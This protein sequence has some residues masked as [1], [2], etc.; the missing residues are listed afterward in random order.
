MSMTSA[1][2][3]I[4]ARDL[5][6]DFPDL[7][8]KSLFGAAPRIPVL[9]GINLSIR[10]G[11]SVGIV[12][13]SGSGKTTLGRCLLRLHE[14]TSGQ[15]LFAG[16]DYTHIDRSNLRSLR[17]QMQMIFQDPLSS[18]NPRRKIGAIV[19]QP[20]L[21]SRVETDRK[22]AEARAIQALRRTGLDEGFAGRYPHELSG[23]QRQRVGIARAIVCE[24]KF[25]LADEIVSGLDV[26]TQAQ[27]LTLLRDLQREMGLSLAFI[28]HDL[29][30]VRVLCDRVVVMLNGKIVEEGRCEDVFDSP[31]SDYARQLIDAVPLPDLDDDWLMQGTEIQREET[32]MDVK[33]KTVLV[34]G[35]NRGIGRAYV[36]ELINRGAAKIYAGVRTSGSMGNAGDRVREIK[37]DV[38]SPADVKAAAESCGDVQILINNAGVNTNDHLIAARDAG[39]AR[40]EMETNYFGTLEMCRAFAPVLEK[41]GPGAIVNMLSIS[42]RAPIPLMGSLSASKAALY[43]LTQSV[44][45]ELAPKGIQVVAVLPG[46][47]DTRMTE[48]FPGDKAAP[49]DIVKAV[50]DGMASGEADIYPDGMSAGIAAGL[51][52]DRPATLAE[53]AGYV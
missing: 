5:T 16:S 23:G 27:I 35:A 50:L 37:I 43:S 41:N 4:E 31:Q 53:L 21:A 1:D 42:G 15:L 30:V 6:M 38:T 46:A 34:T 47:V 40:M 11:E 28:S 48:N 52:A 29:S 3:L 10:V 51:A 32:G 7:A 24:P 17:P 19:A 14:P 22:N 8:A 18:L 9:K 25:I 26:S 45:A 2:L 20:L 12:G 36:D 44:R 13:E 49:A 33:G 39:D